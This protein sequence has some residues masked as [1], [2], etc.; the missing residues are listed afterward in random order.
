[1]LE[2]L[3]PSNPLFTPPPHLQE[4]NPGILFHESRMLLSPPYV[5]LSCYCP[6]HC[7]NATQFIKCLFI[8]APDAK[9]CFI[10]LSQL[11]LGKVLRVGWGGAEQEPSH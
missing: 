5:S 9:L 3:A 1:M 8:I 6:S 10:I 2:R 7:Q 4:L 11:L